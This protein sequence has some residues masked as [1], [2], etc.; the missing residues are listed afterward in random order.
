M[1]KTA[2]I[3]ATLVTLSLAA[4]PQTGQA[5]DDAK[6]AAPSPAD[7]SLVLPH[8]MPHLMRYVGQIGL[9]E[10]RKATLDKYANETIRPALRPLLEEAQRL[11]KEIARAA[12]DGQAGE[13]LAAKLDRLQRVKRDAAEIHIG[14]LNQV[15]RTLSA[16][17]Y[18]H[19]LKLAG[20]E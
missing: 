6:A 10:E 15:R 5:H 2:T 12:L 19:L 11:E 7:Y 18:R 16:E 8:N 17:E 20:A 13:Q 3:L 9:S 14:C 1:K 4:L